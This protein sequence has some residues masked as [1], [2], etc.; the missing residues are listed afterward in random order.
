M[1]AETIIIVGIAVTLIIGVDGVRR[2][3][4]RLRGGNGSGVEGDVC[5]PD[6]PCGPG[7]TCRNNVCLKSTGGLDE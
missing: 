6:I 3:V 4:G 7:L 2:I 5:N 1:K